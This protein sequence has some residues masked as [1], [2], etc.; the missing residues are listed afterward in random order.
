M[1]DLLHDPVFGH[2]V[3]FMT[4]AKLFQY[5]EEIDPSLWR[6]YLDRKQTTDMTLYGYLEDGSLEEKLERESALISETQSHAN[7]NSNGSGANLSE[8]YSQT[9]AG[10]GEY[11]LS[12]TIT[13]QKIDQKKGEMLQW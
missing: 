1:S 10:D 2:A 13:G 11:R 4:K 8:E 6:Q 3:R 5:A 9:R 7:G 12:S